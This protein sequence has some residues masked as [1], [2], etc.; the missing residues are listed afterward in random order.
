M[1]GFDLTMFQENNEKKLDHAAML[2]NA[3]FNRKKIKCK[4][5]PTPAS[6]GEL[7]V[8]CH[9]CQ[10]AAVPALVLPLEGQCQRV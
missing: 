3:V 6:R 1:H 9:L 10:E 7:C 2:C 4:S 8:Q 5:V